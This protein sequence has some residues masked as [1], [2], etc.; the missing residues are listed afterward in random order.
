MVA[1]VSF[2]L[3]EALERLRSDEDAVKT[4]GALHEVLLSTCSFSSCCCYRYN[5]CV[6]IMVLHSSKCAFF[7]RYFEAVLPTRDALKSSEMRCAAVL[8]SPCRSD[9]SCWV[10]PP[11]R[12]C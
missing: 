2:D 9:K 11:Q 8:V 12:E 6:S 10:S 1:V 4:R 3:Q 5:G 7:F